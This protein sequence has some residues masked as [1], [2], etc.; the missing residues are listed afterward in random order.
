MSLQSWPSLASDSLTTA[1][2][3][4]LQP[5]PH[6]SYSHYPPSAP[7]PSAAPPNHHPDGIPG[8]PPSVHGYHAGYCHHYPPLPPN[9]SQRNTD[10]HPPNSGEYSAWRMPSNQYMYPEHHAE[11]PD[12]YPYA[13]HHPGPILYGHA[14]YDHLGPYHE[15]AYNRNPYGYSLGTLPPP[16]TLHMSHFSLGA[17][18]PPERVDNNPSTNANKPGSLGVDKEDGHTKEGWWDGEE[19]R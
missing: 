1:H 15:S 18:I 2:T 14:G 12:Q 9:S 8:A 16:P 10:N 3:S 4:N 13:E 11:L 7:W 19:L 5:P 17:N 6:Q